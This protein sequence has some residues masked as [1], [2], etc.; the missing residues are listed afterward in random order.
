MESREGDQVDSQLSE[1]RVEL[2]GESKA[3]S[4]S[5]HG[6]GDEMVEITVCRGGEL[7]SS[8]ADIVEGFVV[9]DH[10]LISVFNQLMDREGGVVRLNNGVRDLGGR[11][12][13]E[14]LHDSVRIFFSDL[15]DEEGSH[16]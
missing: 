13:G 2:T 9:N 14:G 8:E 12:N 7:E 5:G 10:A 11:D 3:A 15:R 1:I 4:N 16:S 6:S